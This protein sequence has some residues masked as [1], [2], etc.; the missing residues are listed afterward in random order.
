[1]ESAC[2]NH[3]FLSHKC[4]LITTNPTKGLGKILRLQAHITSCCMHQNLEDFEA[5]WP[6][7]RPKF[8]YQWPRHPKRTETQAIES[9]A[10]PLATLLHTWFRRGLHGHVPF[11]C[12]RVSTE[13]SM[14][15]RVPNS[16]N[17]PTWREERVDWAILSFGNVSI[18]LLKNLGPKNCIHCAKLTN[19]HISAAIH[20]IHMLPNDRSIDFACFSDSASCRTIQRKEKLRRALKISHACKILAI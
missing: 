12:Q 10:R 2:K 15:A 7:I 14:P 13:K 8:T 6:R 19:E 9:Q 5:N 4:L 16:C 3:G 20:R 11:V 1:M 17:S 18:R